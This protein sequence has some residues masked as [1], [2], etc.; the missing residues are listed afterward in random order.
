MTS[1]IVGVA[2][3]PLVAAPQ[4]DWNAWEYLGVRGAEFVAAAETALIVQCS[5]EAGEMLLTVRIPHDEN[6]PAE[7]RRQVTVQLDKGPVRIIER[8]E[9][10][11]FPGVF[12]FEPEP[13]LV[14]FLL[15]GGHLDLEFETVGIQ[16][17][18]DGRL[19]TETLDRCTAG[20]RD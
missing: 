7:N 6:A 16:V 8:V 20:Y 3:G 2:L 12:Q 10:R 4:P 9:E 11:P 5:E 19:M 17:P 18:V 14:D 15:D 1:L 13:W